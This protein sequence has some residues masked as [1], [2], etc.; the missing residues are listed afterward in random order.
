M[1]ARVSVLICTYNYARYL[2][3][4]LAS[5]LNQTR[6]PDEVIVLDDGSTDGTPEVMKQFPQVH[7][8]YQKNT[9]KAV[10]FG[11]AF[12][13]STG[14]IICH[15][16]A[17]DYWDPHKLERVLYC[18]AKN[19]NVGGVL[20]EV[21]HVDASGRVIHL[22]WAKTHPKEP[23]ILTLDESKDVS[24]LYPLP[25]AHGQ[26]FG[27]PN[28]TCIRRALLE[29]LLP[30]PPEVGGAVDGLM[31]AA[32][33]RHGVTYLPEA[34][35]AYRIH[36]S[37]AGFGNVAST[38]ETISMW[39]FLLA[40]RNFRRFLSDRH[41]RLLRAKILER[42]AYLSGRTGQNVL[43]G[44]WAGI[45][46]PWILAVNGFCCNWK[47]LA[48]PVLCLLP[49]KRAYKKSQRQATGLSPRPTNSLKGESPDP[50]AAVQ[51]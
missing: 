20:H 14:D 17:D 9:G 50:A 19:P 7:Y 8:V 43:A 29:D 46:V 41:A 10:A 1:S 13:L 25:N 24:F 31:I 16:D 33:L 3:Q 32:A 15:L 34:L 51:H 5:V 12:A 18:F 37:N 27:V 26:F 35:A 4:C 42:K 38:R 48:L 44:T 40:H 39:E 23:V 6:P 22:P 45:R 2:P 11:R 28:T 49:L 36:G 21:T 30:L 47:H